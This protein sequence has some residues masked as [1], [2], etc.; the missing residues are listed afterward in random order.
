MS[1]NVFKVLSEYSE[2]NSFLHGNTL[3]QHKT[4]DFIA[5]TT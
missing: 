3:K 5:K 1:G 4:G 2:V